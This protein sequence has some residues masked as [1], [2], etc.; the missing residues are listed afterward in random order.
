M[1]QVLNRSAGADVSGYI[2]RAGTDPRLGLSEEVQGRFASEGE[3]RQAFLA[4][5]LAPA[6]RH[7]WAE[8]VAVGDDKEPMPLCWFGDHAPSGTPASPLYRRRPLTTQSR[9]V[10]VDHQ[11]ATMQTKEQEPIAAPAADL[12]RPLRGRRSRVVA[13]LVAVLTAATL[14]IAAA[15]GNGSDES[16]TDRPVP[17]WEV[18]PAP[19]TDLP[20]YGSSADG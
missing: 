3:A 13:A 4:L 14:A 2:V 16:P 19:P 12:D 10:H 8:L 20:Y 1:T 17:T 15:S 11:G 18:V 6:Y 9:A 5:R 7:G